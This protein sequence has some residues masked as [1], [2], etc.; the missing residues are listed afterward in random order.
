MSRYVCLVL[1]LSALPAGAQSLVPLSYSGHVYV[2][3]R[4]PM[5]WMAASNFAA[6]ARGHL[7]IVQDAAENNFLYQQ[8]LAHGF[9]NT[10]ADGG[11]S[12]YAWLGASDAA[13]EGAWRWVDGALVS[14]GFTN[15]GSGD[16]GSE[17]DNFS[18]I[19]H[20][21]ALGL[22]KWPAAYAGIGFGNTSQWNDVS[23]S[24]SVL[25]T[26]VEFDDPAADADGDGA[27]DWAELI[28]GTVPTS[29][30]SVLRV[31][32]L[33]TATLSWTGV[34][35]RV[36]RI[37]EATNLPPAWTLLGAVTGAGGSVTFT[38]APG[39]AGWRMVEVR[40]P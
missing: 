9:T 40:A 33:A 27:P 18:G 6:A 1:A 7:P 14:A 28:A 25:G 32:G 15:W 2:V 24:N 31:H 11:G 30:A 20:H 29:S 8:A 35:G 5:T 37:H 26:F 38:Q 22:Q 16:F 34:A 13:A 10:A 19:Q 39:A 4:T 21:L 36:Y 3:V 12:R 23:G 17:P